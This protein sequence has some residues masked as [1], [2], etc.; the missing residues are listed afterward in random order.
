M[1]SRI[2]GYV[3]VST[4]EQNEAR[5]IEEL[6]KY[7]PKEQIIVD[8]ASGKD[9][10]R[11]GYQNLKKEL[12]AG[13][14]L[15]IKELDRLG[16]NK[17]HIKDELQELQKMKIKVIILNI[18][19][20]KALL[21]ENLS[22]VSIIEMINNILIE[23]LSTIAEEERIKIR[24]RQAEGIKIAKEQGRELGRPQKKITPRVE[25]IL[26]E[27]RAGLKTKTLASKELN[28]SRTQLDRML[29]RL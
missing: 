12:K 21:Q 3:R 8:K 9:M 17:Q 4:K 11:E 20:T 27:V 16:R 26:K 18:P 19:T 1:M 13:D 2:Y 15:V 28:T 7:V 10:E 14:M 25:K 5:Q 22:N 23:V 6:L 29:T 24:T